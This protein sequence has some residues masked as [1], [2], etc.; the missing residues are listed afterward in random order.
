MNLSYDYFL[1]DTKAKGGWGGTRAKLLKDLKAEEEELT[2]LHIRKAAGA[3]VKMVIDAT[4]E[5]IKS[6]HRELLI[7]TRP[8]QPQIKTDLST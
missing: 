7:A 8:R 5:R 2:H 1:R 6:I 4:N 3:D